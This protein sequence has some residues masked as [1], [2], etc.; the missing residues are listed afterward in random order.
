MRLGN[1]TSHDGW[2][3]NFVR[4]RTLSV[5]Q[6]FVGKGRW[7]FSTGSAA[8]HLLRGFFY[9][10]HASEDTPVRISRPARA[11]ISSG[12]SRNSRRIQVRARPTAPD[13]TKS[14]Q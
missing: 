13:T 14:R 8:E 5:M 2:G 1:D 6:P 3:D 11:A 10:N 4:N 9:A 7:P 12:D